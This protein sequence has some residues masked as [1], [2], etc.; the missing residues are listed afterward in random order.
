[1]S[2][3]TTY[4]V[5]TQ[6]PGDVPEEWGRASRDFLCR[7]EAVAEQHRLVRRDGYGPTRIVETS[8]EDAH[9]IQQREADMNL[10]VRVLDEL[11]SALVRDHSRQCW[12]LDD[13]AMALMQP[14][15]RALLAGIL[16]N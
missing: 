2:T 1:M 11:A 5:E 12:V 3:M 7:E 4:H 10:S 8:W 16:K 14:R 6:R 15:T 9:S 13:R